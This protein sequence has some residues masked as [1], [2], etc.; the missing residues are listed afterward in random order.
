MAWFTR[1]W[2][3]SSPANFLWTG[4]YHAPVVALLGPLSVCKVH[5]HTYSHSH[6]RELLC[7]CNGERLVLHLDCVMGFGLSA[8]SNCS[9]TMV[10]YTCRLHSI[11]TRSTHPIHS[12]HTYCRISRILFLDAQWGMILTGTHY[13]TFISVKEDKPL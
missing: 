1:T 10:Q 11:H 4:W 12:I 7:L 13:T 6:T 8:C 9:L 3:Y 2:T 5:A